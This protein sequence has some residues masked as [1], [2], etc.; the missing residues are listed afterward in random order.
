MFFEFFGQLN[1]CLRDVPHLLS[2][3]FKVFCFLLL[4]EVFRQ[5]F[6]PGIREISYC[7]GEGALI[8]PVSEDSIP[9]LLKDLLHLVP[10]VI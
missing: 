3:F 6:T 5:L 7:N 9:I 2:H 10:V 1:L 8:P 4:F